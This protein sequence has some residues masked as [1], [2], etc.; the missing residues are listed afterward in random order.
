MFISKELPILQ[1]TVMSSSSGLCAPRRP[2]EPENGGT[3]CL[4]NVRDYTPNDML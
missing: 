4:Q 2:L 1:R 3:T